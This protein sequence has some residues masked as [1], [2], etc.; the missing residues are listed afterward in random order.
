M[1]LHRIVAALGGDLYSGG[2]RAS[3]PGPGHSASDRSVSL[4]LS[5]DRLVAHSFGSSDWRAVRD[6]LVRAGLIDHAGRLISGP[7]PMRSETPPRPDRAC[8]IAAARRLWAAAQ[9]VSPA[10]L[11]RRHLDRRGIRQ[12]AATLPALRHHPC[13]PLAAYRGGGGGVPALVAAIRHPDGALV[14]AELTYLA[15]NGERDRRLRVSRKTVGA[16]PPGSAVR[17]Q[18][19]AS[20]MLVGEGVM[21]SLSG[22]DRFGLPAWALL[23][24]NN[25]AAWSPPI[26]VERV[27]I[28]A[29][30][31]AGGQ[32]AARQLQLRLRQLRLDVAVTT[33]PEPFD[34]WNAVAVAESRKEGG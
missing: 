6:Q 1:T 32:S 11:S 7:V 22:G 12:D 3:V 31:G 17:L 24:A 16:V 13:A 28:A 5:G 8:R 15:P 30:R 18:P 27:L 9:P 33:P 21:T 20:T 19:P 23:S 4:L 14:A 26:G 34:D 29:D 2:L 10:C 25:L